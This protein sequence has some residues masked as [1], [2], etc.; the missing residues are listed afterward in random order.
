MGF[1]FK[2]GKNRDSVTSSENPYDS[3]EYLEYSE[4][5]DTEDSDGS[6]EATA[7][8]D[9]DNA[10]LGMRQSDWTS[11]WLHANNV[12]AVGLTTAGGKLIGL[13]QKCCLNSVNVAEGRERQMSSILT[14]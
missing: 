14:F 8:G 6:V 1:E 5:P 3:D 2:K 7:P 4:S 11:G 9:F 10:T 13:F 12:D